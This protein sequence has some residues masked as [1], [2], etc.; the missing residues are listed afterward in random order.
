MV[1]MNNGN[2]NLQKIRDTPIASLISK[3][4]IIDP[5][6]TLSSVIA[7]ILEKN[8]FDVFYFDGKSTLS[9]NMRGLL[10]AK[11]I[12]K[13]S[14][15]S[16]IH[17]IPFIGPND[18]IQKAAKIISDYRTRGVAIVE[19]N[20][21]VGAVT[22]KKIL[23]LLS[24]K[25]NK[26]IK[27][28]MI[29]TQNPIT[30]SS[31]EYLSNAKKIMI[32]KRLDHLPVITHGKIKQVLTPAHIIEYILPQE[33]QG[34]K[35]LGIKTAHKLEFEIGNMGTTRVPQCTPDD[36]LNV[37]LKSILKND[38][39]CCLVKIGETLQGIITFRDILG[40]LI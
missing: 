35:S 32:S 27:A 38:T 21:I 11:N 23:E 22:A 18:T 1:S 20:K 36:D 8:A 37:I 28:K 6:D 2:E 34:K 7:N 17:P 13:M 3:A 26:S 40:L 5:E 25:D 33:R 16:L 30:I 24:T 39:S 14:I 29:Y 9:T 4:I 31:K 10:K 12:S 19:K 15:E